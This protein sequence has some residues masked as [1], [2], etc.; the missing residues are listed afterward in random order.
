M[1]WLL[2]AWVSVETLPPETKRSIML[3]ALFLFV[4]LLAY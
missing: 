4:F 1:D 2:K 3:A